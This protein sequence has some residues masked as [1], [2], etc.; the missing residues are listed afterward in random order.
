MVVDGPRFLL[1]HLSYAQR[2]EVTKKSQRGHGR[3]QLGPRVVRARVSPACA[4]LQTVLV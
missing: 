3:P 2:A 4:G 1:V